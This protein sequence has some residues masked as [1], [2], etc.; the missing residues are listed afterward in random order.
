MAPERQ[1]LMST[2]TFRQGHALIVGVAAY[3]HIKPLPSNVL[4]DARDVA[5][6]LTSSQQC[7]YDP[8]NV[9][10][11]LDGAATRDAILNGLQ[12]LSLR[13][14][15]DDTAC[16]YFSG[17]GALLGGVDGDESNLLPVDCRFDNIAASSISTAEFS[18]ALQAIKARRLIVFL[19][20][21]HAAGAGIL[22]SVDL[23]IGASLGVSEKTLARLAEG[24]GRILMASSKTNE[25]SLIMPGARNS[26]FTQ[27]LI[28]GLGGAADPN[29]SG[30][31]K[32]FDL[33][34]YVANRV[35]ATTGDRQHPIF[36]ASHVEQNFPVALSRSS[37][38]KAIASSPS[39]HG[40][41][42]CQ[43][44][45]SVLPDLYPTGPSDQEIWARAGGDISQLRLQGTGRA[46]WFAA[47]R[48]LEQG[49]GGDKISLR[50]LVE[51]A[52]SDFPQHSV[53]QALR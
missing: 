27:A 23:G 11:L 52:L 8:L 19:D 50:S 37:A 24:A 22:K 15:P 39:A 3:R 35:P 31:I 38:K 44:L 33:F 30:L 53:L 41:N 9:T 49:G 7:G 40:S 28:E 36:K 42:V 5:A 34:N 32:V 17:H 6:I 51:V 16:L 26:A 25:T 43:T 2:S 14:G 45:R 12:D 18:A 10:Q 1:A 13:T 29:G 48:T 47:L 21:C 46:M 20:A 4:D